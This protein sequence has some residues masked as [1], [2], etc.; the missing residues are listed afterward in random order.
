MERKIPGTS[1]V[2]LTARELGSPDSLPGGV[3]ACLAALLLAFSAQTQASGVVAG[4]TEFTQIANNIEL[5]AQVGEA[6]Q[7]TSNTLMTAQSTMQMLR[8]LPESVMNEAMSGLPVEKVQAMADAYK[9]MSQAT[10]VYKD[11]E[12]VLRKAQSDAERLG[13]KPSELLQHKANAAAM[14][15][16][17]YKQAYDEEQAKLARLAETSKEVQKQANAVRSIDSNIGG[18]QFL[19]SQNVQV[20]ASLADISGS[21]AKANALAFD[22]AAKA[23]NASKAENEFEMKRREEFLRNQKKAEA[24]RNAISIDGLIPK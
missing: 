3:A 11:A 2:G 1:V 5:V 19:A 8:Q 13:M 16:G 6:V 21:I 18:I 12:N 15:G 17:V 22:E 9:V 20:Q 23:N 10:A 4:A 14:H 24:M 7:T